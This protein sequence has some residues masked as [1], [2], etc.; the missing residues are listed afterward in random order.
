MATPAPVRPGSRYCR[1]CG[2]SVT[3]KG[4]GYVWCENTATS[5]DALD[6]K[7]RCELLGMQ[8]RSYCEQCQLPVNGAARCGNVHPPTAP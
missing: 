1:D 5:G 7:D 4:G 6:P 8:R 3:D 2:G